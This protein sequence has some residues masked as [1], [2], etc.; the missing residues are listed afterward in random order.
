MCV[1][2]SA[3][4][5]SSPSVSL[6]VRPSVV[7]FCLPLS[8]SLCVRLSVVCFCRP[9]VFLCASACLLSVSLFPISVSMC[10][11]LSVFC[12]S[13]P[14]LCFSVR[15][16]I[17]CLF[18]SFPSLFLS[19]SVCLLS[20]SVCPSLFLSAGPNFS[21][22]WTGLRKSNNV[23]T[24]YYNSSY[25]VDATDDVSGRWEGPTYDPC[26]YTMTSN[27]VLLKSTSLYSSYRPVCE[28]SGTGAGKD[29][30]CLSAWVHHV[31]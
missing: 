24:W 11:R 9:P 20:V 25:V 6:R 10:V 31:R 23:W 15:P 29:F 21:Q 12:F 19:A 17:C 8:V 3:L 5:F 14:H 2:L 16:S 22:H 4:C 28:D 7:C 30:T 27:Q 1:R 26:A 18:L 13:L